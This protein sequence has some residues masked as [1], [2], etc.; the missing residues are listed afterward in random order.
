MET[1][2]PEVRQYFIEANTEGTPFD[3]ET[4]DL[5]YERAKGTKSD[6]PF[7]TLRDVNA[8]GYEFLRHSL[9]AR[10]ADDLDP[11]VRLGGAE[12]TAA[13]RHRDAQRVGDELRCPVRECDR[14][15]QCGSGP[16]RVRPRH[17]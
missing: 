11:R 7:G 8:T 4:R 16:G 15:A 17:R 3:R 2:R 1:I 13:L 14:R 12:C 10:T 6:E 5:V 9:R